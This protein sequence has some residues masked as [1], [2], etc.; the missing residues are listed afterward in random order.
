MY[1]RPIRDYGVIILGGGCAGLSLARKLV[2]QNYNYPILLL[3]QRAQYTHDRTWSGWFS[4]DQIQGLDTIPKHI[5]TSWSFSSNSEKV[6]HSSQDRAYLSIASRDFYTDTLELLEQSPLVDLYLGTSI[7]ESDSEYL[8]SEKSTQTVLVDTIGVTCK[9]QMYQ[10]TLTSS[11]HSLSSHCDGLWQRFVGVTV[12][13][14]QPLFTSQELTQARLMHNMEVNEHGFCFNY[15][16]PLTQF[17]ALVETTFFTTKTLNSTYLRQLSITAAKDY[18]QTHNNLK[19]TCNSTLAL[20]FTVSEEGH[21]PMQV[22]LAEPSKIWIK[23]T[24]VILGGTI[25]G[26]LRP[27]SGYAFASIQDWANKVVENLISANHYVV[28]SYQHYS[29]TILYLDRIF[30]KVLERYPAIAPKLFLRMAAIL[31]AKQ[32]ALFMNHQAG[33]LVWLKVIWAMPKLP[34]ISA[35]WFLGRKKEKGKRKKEKGKR[36][37][38]MLN[39]K[40]H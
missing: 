15:I 22:S 32:F 9:S 30:L 40:Q 31:S 12:S 33:F 28:D 21:L 19:N 23:N 24:N 38:E 3:E 18:F 11:E 29:K 2:Q 39:A 14:E 16:L 36:K 35:W 5:Y 34:F 26:A 1:N 10:T 37:K 17:T 25:A 7:V 4:A 13:A 6:L 8:L 20:T 27:S